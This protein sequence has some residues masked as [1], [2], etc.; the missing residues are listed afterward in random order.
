MDAAD[1][2]RDCSVLLSRRHLPK[3]P[4][5]AWRR[6][7]ARQAS[8][9]TRCRTVRGMNDRAADDSLVLRPD[10]EGQLFVI[11]VL[12][13]GE[14]RI[15]RYCYR[16]LNGREL[17]FPMFYDPERPGDCTRWVHVG[18]GAVAVRRI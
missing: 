12:T 17:R 16:A 5:P 3:P 7:L 13:S 6:V 2:D 10:D 11:R 18:W 1:Q 14:E 4:T 8:F 9:H 15:A